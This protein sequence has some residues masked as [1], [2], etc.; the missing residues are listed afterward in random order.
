VTQWFEIQADI[1]DS[2]K[3]AYSTWPAG[4][5]YEIWLFLWPAVGGEEGGAGC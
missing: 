5:V 2:I 3:Q 1:A 4:A